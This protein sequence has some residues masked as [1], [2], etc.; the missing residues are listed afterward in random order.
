MLS[1]IGGMLQFDL[2]PFIESSDPDEPVVTFAVW[3]SYSQNIEAYMKAEKV[4]EIFFPFLQ[5]RH[6]TKLGNV[7]T[8]VTYGK[9]GVERFLKEDFSHPVYLEIKEGEAD[10]PKVLKKISEASDKRYVYFGHKPSTSQCK[11]SKL[12]DFAPDIDRIEMLRESPHFESYRVKIG[13]REVAHFDPGLTI[14]ARSPKEFLM[15]KKLIRG[16]VQAAPPTSDRDSIA[17]QEYEFFKRLE[18]EGILKYEDGF[19]IPINSFIGCRISSYLGDESHVHLCRIN[20]QISLLALADIDLS[21]APDKLREFIHYFKKYLESWLQSRVNM[22]I[23]MRVSQEMNEFTFVTPMVSLFDMEGVLM[24]R[25]HPVKKSDHLDRSQPN[26]CDFYCYHKQ[27]EIVLEAKL[28]R[29]ETYKESYNKIKGDTTEISTQSSPG[30][31]LCKYNYT[32]KV[33]A[34][35]AA[36]VKFMKVNRTLA[37]LIAAI[38]G[39]FNYYCYGKGASAPHESGIIIRM[40]LLSAHPKSLTEIIYLY[41]EDMFNY[42]QD[43]KDACVI[44]GKYDDE[45]TAQATFKMEDFPKLETDVQ[46]LIE[47]S[48]NMPHVR[49]ELEQARLDRERELEA[50]YLEPSQVRFHEFTKWIESNI[51]I[52]KEK[53]QVTTEFVGVWKLATLLVHM[54]YRSMTKVYQ[55]LCK[56]FL[57][58]KIGLNAKNLL[59]TIDIPPYHP[60]CISYLKSIDVN[61]KKNN[62][63]IKKSIMPMIN[64]SQCSKQSRLERELVANPTN[65]LNEFEAVV[66]RLV[67]SIKWVY[68]MTAGC[69]AGFKSVRIVD[70]PTAAAMSFGLEKPGTQMTLAFDLEGGGDV[71]LVGEDF[72]QLLFE[73][74][75]SRY[76]T[77]HKMDFTTNDVT[78]A[79]LRVPCESAKRGLSSTQSTVIFREFGEKCYEMT[80]TRTDFEQACDELFAKTLQITKE[81]RAKVDRKI[82]QVVLVGGS[83]AIPKVHLQPKYLFEMMPNQSLNPGQAVAIGAAI[84]ASTLWNGNGGSLLID[85]VP[86]FIGYRNRLDHLGTQV[87]MVWKDYGMRSFLLMNDFVSGGC[88]TPE[89]P[90]IARETVHFLDVHQELSAHYRGRFCY[91]RIYLLPYIEQ[92]DHGNYPNL[93]KA[94][95]LRAKRSGAFGENDS[96]YLMSNVHATVPD[97]LLMDYNQKRMVGIDAASRQDLKRMGY[98]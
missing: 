68:Y 22:S 23:D 93:Y 33:V 48:P 43:K 42:T 17:K 67:V 90:T 12:I 71:H 10:N 9:A 5:D 38:S 51:K 29:A 80:V 77:D 98:L 55:T 8:E 20:A 72:T 14:S 66:H 76:L 62:K 31:A 75:S 74:V 36:E 78:K 95:I 19:F 53:N 94:A 92:I 30:Q 28:K 54:S 81:C 84:Q 63:S 3:K 69:K 11:E 52:A 87:L 64:M 73:H 88:R 46:K 37:D 60:P 41:P 50:N 35:A 16:S 85:L 39:F 21:S 44:I 89:I 2:N 86:H 32:D 24:F 45:F 1:F 34:D 18:F 13:G 27:L 47:S 49:R 79:R 97:T 91:A 82:D 25:E 58:D 40:L 96:K 7:P 59:D 65:D 56:A 70:E 4:T 6:S 26:R 83:T 15:L 57:K 61:M